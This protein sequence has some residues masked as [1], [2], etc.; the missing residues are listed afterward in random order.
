MAKYLII[1]LTTMENCKIY[2]ILIYFTNITKITWNGISDNV[3][4]K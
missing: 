3:I 1:I 2:R 4:A